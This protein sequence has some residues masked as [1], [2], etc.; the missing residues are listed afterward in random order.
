LCTKIYPLGGV[1]RACPWGAGPV[2]VN[3]GHPNISESKRARKLKLKMPLDI[4][5]FSPRVHKNF[6]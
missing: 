4:V 2:N 5:T 3:L 6:R 1:Q